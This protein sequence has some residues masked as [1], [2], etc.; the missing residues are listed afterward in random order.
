MNAHSE[1]NAT[2]LAYHL[3][4]QTNPQALSREGAYIIVKGDGTHVIDENGKRY[5]DAMAGLWCASLGFNNQRLGRAAAKQYEELGYYHSFYGRTNPKAATLSKKL[6]ELTGMPNGK[7]FF[8]TSGS[9]A[10]ETMV[11]L[12]WLYHA[13]RGKPT[14]RKVIARDRAFHGSTIVAGSMCGLEMMHREFGLPLPGFIHTL[15]PNAYRV[16]LPGESETEFVARLAGELERMILR[17]G[18]DTIAAFI[19]EPVIAGGG[20]IPPPEGYFEAVQKILAKYDIL[21]LDDEVVCGF[22]RTGN[23]FGRETVCM[24]PDMMSLAKGITS[25]YFPL[26][27]VIVSP[28]ILEAVERYNEGGTSFGHGFTNAAHPVGAAV[29]AET[30]AIYE[31][32]DIVA[33]VRKMGALLH[34]TLA[35]VTKDSPIVGNLRGVGLMYGVELVEDPATGSPFAPA[36][37]VGA[38]LAASAYEHGLVVR[39]M[40]DTVG[41]CPPLIIDEGDVEEIGSKMEKALRETDKAIQAKSI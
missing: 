31:E 1:I 19:A 23:W 2:D 14:K 30:I 18:P 8:V 13:S 5:I 33:H 9:E 29:A 28:K 36:R 37:Q 40:R 32:L 26:A 24:A 17:E 4:S 15:C 7:A 41:F 16:K 20:I 10:N 21:C 34:Q 38:R 3:H 25:S 12:A 22:G 27:A 6:V 11:K 39:A 35:D